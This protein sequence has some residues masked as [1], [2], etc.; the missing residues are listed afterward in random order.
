MI[1]TVMIRTI[2]I[3]FL[4]RKAHLCDAAD[5]EEQEYW[6]NSPK[7]SRMKICMYLAQDVRS[8]AERDS[9]FMRP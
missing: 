7:K 4:R 1:I 5:C 6:K 3:I 2:M 9:F 8:V